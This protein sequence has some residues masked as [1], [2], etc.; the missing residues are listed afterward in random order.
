MTKNGRDEFWDISKA[1]LMWLVILGHSIQVMVGEGFF[2]HPVFKAIYL[3]HLPVFFFISGYFAYTSIN[4][5]GW[6]ALGRTTL[7]LLAPIFTFGSLEAIYIT[8]QHSFSWSAVLNCFICFWFLWSLF[9]CQVLGHLILIIAHPLWK[10]VCLFLPIT[11]CVFFPKCL[12]YA[13]YLSFSWPFFALGMFARFKNFKHE[14][15]SSNW[16]WMF[17]PATAAFFF[18]RND[19]YI[20]LCP[21]RASLAS[22]GIAAF[23]CAA[24]VSAG[25][26]FLALMHQCAAKLRIAKLGTATL[27]IYVVQSVFCVISGRFDYPDFCSQIWFIIF[28]SLLLYIIAFYVYQFTRKIPLVGA[29]AYGDL[30]STNR[31][32]K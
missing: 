13:D 19:W 10:F 23:R 6:K 15:I 12:P 3:F 14:T 20:Y 25:A 8:Y 7:R 18:F 22:I 16:L 4:R 17:F 2:S 26:F 32:A 21:L 28:L 11:L 30:T 1:I 27:G 29:M 24:A 9:E 31:N 5:R